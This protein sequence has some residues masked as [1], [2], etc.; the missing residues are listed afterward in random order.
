MANCCYL[1]ITLP[2]RFKPLWEN[3]QLCLSLIYNWS[4]KWDKRA[5][6]ITAQRRLY[7]LIASYSKICFIKITTF[8][9]LK[10]HQIL[11]LIW[12]I[13]P[14]LQKVPFHRLDNQQPIPYLIC[15]HDIRLEH[16]KKVSPV[17]VKRVHDSTSNYVYRRCP[18]IRSLRAAENRRHG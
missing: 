8:L 17:F 5:Y 1:C 10:V 13:V 16:L 18:I 6:W 15:V 7:I 9:L 4:I 11:S 2:I 3:V 12:F 14:D